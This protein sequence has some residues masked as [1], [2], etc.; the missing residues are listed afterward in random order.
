MSIVPQQRR[1]VNLGSPGCQ[2]SLFAGPDRVWYN[3]IVR[4]GRN[5]QRIAVQQGRLERRRGAHRSGRR[6][7]VGLDAGHLSRQYK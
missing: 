7:E 2:A 4:G 1:F 5:R 6:P 3:A